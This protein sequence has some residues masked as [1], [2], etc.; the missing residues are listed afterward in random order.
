MIDQNSVS[1]H[2]AVLDERGGV[3]EKFQTFGDEP[4]IRLVKI[5][6]HKVLNFIRPLLT[7][8]GYCRLARSS[9]KYA[10]IGITSHDFI[11]LDEDRI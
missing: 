11:L 10:A 8:Q 2:S 1:Y 4:D 9:W 5:H 3:L 6:H 7:P